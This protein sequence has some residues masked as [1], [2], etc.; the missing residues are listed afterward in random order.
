M[1]KYVA[2][3]HSWHVHSNGFKVV[4]LDGTKEEAY[5]QAMKQCREMDRCGNSTDFKLIEIN[6]DSD[7]TGIDRIWISKGD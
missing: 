5:C 2:I 1:K 6:F 7:K 3:F 4:E